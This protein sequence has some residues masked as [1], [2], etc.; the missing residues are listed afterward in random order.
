[1]NDVT[2][3]RV[4]L[5]ICVSTIASQ[6]LCSSIPNESWTTLPNLLLLC[7]KEHSEI[8][9]WTHKSVCQGAELGM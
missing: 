7:I 3:G 5:V 6:K 4:L 2:F 9:D 8:Y 1:M